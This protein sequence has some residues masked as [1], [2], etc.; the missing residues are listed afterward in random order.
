MASQARKLDKGARRAIFAAVALL[1][2]G[3]IIFVGEHV[4]AQLAARRQVIKSDDDQL[5]ILPDGSTLLARHGSTARI[6]AHWLE[7][8]PSGAKTFDVGD[9]NFSPST[10]NLTHDGWE[11]VAQFSQMLKAHHN[12]TAVLL[13]T[14]DQGIPATVEL[15]HKRADRIR[16]E[17][18]NQGVDQEQISV[19]KEGFEAGHNTAA[20]QGIEVVLT[21]RA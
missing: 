12:V 6:M 1:L 14:A 20:D 13:Y 10:A 3:P 18:L 15:E 8:D 4:T 7:A 5:V 21:N 16:N 19:S 2:A 17:A 11:H 9:D